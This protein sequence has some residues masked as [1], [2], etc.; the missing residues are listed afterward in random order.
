METQN[1]TPEKEVIELLANHDAN[2][3]RALSLEG[4]Y[5]D[6]KEE[7]DALEESLTKSSYL[8]MMEDAIP[9]EELDIIEVTNEA[10]RT[11]G[12]VKKEIPATKPE[13]KDVP[14]VQ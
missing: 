7:W 11:I 1:F 2:M 3:Q 13:E 5:E 10:G 12:Y 4:S 6:N 8:K 14:T 9:A